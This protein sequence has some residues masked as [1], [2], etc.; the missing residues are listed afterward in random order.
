MSKTKLPE[1]LFRA[2]RKDE[3]EKG[4]L[5]PKVPKHFTSKATFPLK[6]PINFN[7]SKEHSIVDHVDPIRLDGKTG[8]V[9]TTPKFEIEKYYAKNKKIVKIDTKKFNELNIDAIIVAE[10]IDSS[11]IPKPEDEEI[12]LKYDKSDTLPK[13]I[14]EEIIEI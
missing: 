4:V 14:I 11:R 9:S 3:I 10:V 1:Y 12:L 13:E 8:Y 7:N 5:I 6:F 2:I